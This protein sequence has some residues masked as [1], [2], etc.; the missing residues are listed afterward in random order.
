MRVLLCVLLSLSI[1]FALSGQTKT[2]FSFKTIC[3][4]ESVAS[5]SDEVLKLPLVKPYH[6]GAICRWETNS[7]VSTK[8]PFTF[9]L[10]SADYVKTLENQYVV[11]F[12]QHSYH[13]KPRP[14][15]GPKRS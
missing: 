13:Y 5:M 12:G 4:P 10:G 11:N 6:F 8:V 9:R 3:L 14:V 2:N 15:Q 7:Q 1:N